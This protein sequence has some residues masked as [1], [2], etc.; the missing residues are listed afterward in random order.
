VLGDHPDGGAISVLAGRFGPYVKW[1]K[2]NATIPKSI[3]VETIT[4]N[5]ALDLI[6]ERDGKPS[7]A[8]KA[9]TKA[10]PAKAAPAK[11]RAAAA[12]KKAPAKKAPVK[13]AAGKR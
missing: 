5:D 3:A 11:P 9:P 8:G 1:G 2:V 13:K 7:K 12:G 6:A 4:L 10:A